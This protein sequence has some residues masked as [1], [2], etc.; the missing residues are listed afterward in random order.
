MSEK[1]DIAIG[2]NRKETS[3]KNKEWTWSEL[4]EKLSTTHRTA[5][6]QTEYLAAKK[7]RQDEIKDI[8]GFVG[9]YLTTGR[10]KAGNVLHRQLITLDADYGNAEFWDDLQLLYSNCAVIY[11]T[12]KHTAD[13][14][15]LRLIMLL[16]R[17]VR[18]DEYEAIARKIAG[19]IDIELF[20]PT[21]F[22]PERLMYWPSTSKDAAYVFEAQDGP[23]LCADEI[24]ESYRDW[25]DSSEWPVSSRVDKI[26]Q[27][28]IQKQ[29]DPLEKPG[30]IGAYCRT[31]TIQEVLE[32]QLA[33]VYD[34][35]SI[36][37]R[38]SYKEGST[39][40]GLVVYD[41]KYAFSHHG[42]D[43]TSGKLCNAFDLVRIHKF[44]LRDEDVIAGTP[45]N[46][47]PS[48][49]AMIEFATKDKKVIVKL[50]T[51]KL[52]NARAEFADLGAVEETDAEP[53][54]SDWTGKLEID[55]KGRNKNTID[56]CLL[57]FANDSYFKGR[58]AYDDFEKCEV[59]LRDL[60]WRKIDKLNRRLIDSDDANIRHYLEKNYSINSAVKVKDGLDITVRKNSIH[61]VRDYL[62][63]VV[64][65]NIER[66]DTLFIVYL[67]AE[68]TPYIRAVTRKAL[69]AA[70][71][72]IFKPGV[73]FDEVLTLIGEQGIGKST[74]LK[75]LG[76]LWFSDSFN[77]HMLKSKEAPEQLQG[78]WLVEIG[79]L[80][81]FKKADVES[82]KSFI[83]KVED[84]YRVAFGKRTNSFPRQCIFFGSTNNRDF[85][86]DQTGNRR[87][88]P[89]DTLIQPPTK[90][91]F[92]DLNSVEVG[93]IWA[94]AVALYKKGEDL[95]LPKELEEIASKVQAAHC[96]VDPKAGII[97]EYLNKLLP[98]NWDELDIYGR[99][100]FLQGD[101]LGQK[102][103]VER[104]KVCVAE[105]CCEALGAY[106]KDIT[107]VNTKP[108][109]A[110]MRNMPGWG[111][112]KS[113]GYKFKL[114]GNQK[115]YFRI[116]TPK[117]ACT[118]AVDLA[119]TEN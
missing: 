52:D 87:F 28:S 39:A 18:P 116:D 47:L 75:K 74:I 106:H 11:S 5:E 119:Y 85:L 46:K 95:H 77:F 30:V 43:P 24:L 38:Y 89:V 73:K 23:P 78:V 93:Q 9:G 81:G 45:G 94:E 35:C 66:V 84:R 29:G 60:P 41:D 80:A 110:I 63:S 12:H 114:Y 33:D 21:T 99:R 79:E 72:R 16:D 104:K 19:V 101:E 25:K 71:A 90:N 57:I 61:P 27:R 15:R 98:D 103:T 86:Q 64:W 2:R 108:I 83:S 53:E 50:N 91:V 49:V 111:E 10:R 65:D 107:S 58:V 69:V 13:K 68:N 14:P 62:N 70:V 55:V 8:G 59:A 44:G 54:N 109:H 32:G 40:A 96:E 6:T 17:P 67:G 118:V 26:L 97:E 56:N 42:T 3:W 34:S 115:A 51:E 4:V 7:P 100:A 113:K 76:G 117:K 102:G 1:F 48:Y 37:G 31:Y 92:K 20:D 112:A 82:A 88:W 36:E 22:Q 105:I